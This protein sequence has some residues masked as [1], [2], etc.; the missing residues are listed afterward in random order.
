MEDHNIKLVSVRDKI[1]NNDTGDDDNGFRFLPH[2]YSDNQSSGKTLFA[3]SAIKVIIDEE[4][5]T[6]D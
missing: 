3:M 5:K 4:S 6:R 2:M 1:L